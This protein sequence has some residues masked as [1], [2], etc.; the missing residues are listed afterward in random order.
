MSGDKVK[1]LP[2]Q[3]EEGAPGWDL[4]ETI[5]RLWHDLQGKVNR[6]AIREVLADVLPQYQDA[7]ILTYVPIFVRRDALEIL[8]R[9]RH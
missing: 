1:M 8:S 3:A 6:Q 7:R 5:D 2:K 4:D 9:R